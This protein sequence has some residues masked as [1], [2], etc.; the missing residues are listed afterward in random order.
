MSRDVKYIGM[1]VHNPPDV[2]FFRC[3]LLF[4]MSDRVVDLHQ[5]GAGGHASVPNATSNIPE[6]CYCFVITPQ[7]MRSPEL[8]EGSVFISSGLA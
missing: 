3:T 8:P 6:P 1:D 5:A 7:A 2:H 4:R